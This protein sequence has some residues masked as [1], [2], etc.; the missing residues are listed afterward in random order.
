MGAQR[1]LRLQGG[2]HSMEKVIVTIKECCRNCVFDLELPI[3]QKMELLIMDIV[4]A[5]GGYMPEL[6]YMIDRLYIVQ[7]RTSSKL[8]PQKT[9]YEEK[10][11]NGDILLLKQTD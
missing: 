3:N 1:E 11:R 9:L 5:I 7:K 10:V 4:Q 8:D 6:M 2:D